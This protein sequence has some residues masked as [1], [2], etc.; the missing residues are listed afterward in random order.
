MRRRGFTLIEL[1]V[2]IAIIGVLVAMLLPAVQKVREAAAR[3]SCRNNMKQIGVATHAYH[4]VYLIL[5]PGYL[6]DF[7]PVSKLD[8]F[9]TFSGNDP[10]WVGALSYLLPY[11]EQTNLFQSM[12][13]GVPQDYFSPAKGMSVGY[14]AFWNYASTWNAANT[15][16]KVY[17]CPADNPF[18]QANGVFIINFQPYTAGT[19]SIGGEG[20]YF[21][22][23]GGGNGLGRTDY[24]G[25][26]GW[27]GKANANCNILTWEG[28]YDNRSTVSLSNVT[29]GDGTA[30]TIMYG[31]CLG[32]ASAG[33]GTPT[34][35]NAWMGAISIPTAWGIWDPGDWYVLTSRHPT[36]VQVCMVDGSVH[37]MK[38]NADGTVYNFDASSWHDGSSYDLAVIMN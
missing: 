35:A 31:E 19:C 20:V 8:A 13:L 38:K 25:C 3:I 24:A 9:P 17:Q 4:D 12:M 10:Q 2:V 15:Q 28:V 30:Y 33:Q 18:N 23:N 22:N 16:I 21:P 34:F 5:P 11:V 32:T 14:N 27:G 37:G 1:L 7:P 26:Q 6:G 36:V 29:D